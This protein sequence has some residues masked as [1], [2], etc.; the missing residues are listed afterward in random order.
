VLCGLERADF[1]L[2][3]TQPLVLLQTTYDHAF[4]FNL[5]RGVL[6]TILC[7]GLWHS[8]VTDTFTNSRVKRLARFW[9]ETALFGVFAIFSKDNS[10]YSNFGGV[11]LRKRR[12][13]LLLA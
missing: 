8:L 6:F 13:S 4:L 11:L 7:H 2:V 9:A 3:Y 12:K 1:G 5:A 10:R